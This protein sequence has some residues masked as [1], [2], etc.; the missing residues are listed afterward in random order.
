[1]GPFSVITVK[2]SEKASESCFKCRRKVLKEH[3]KFTGTCVNLSAAGNVSRWHA[4]MFTSWKKRCT[5]LWKAVK[6]SFSVVSRGA[7]ALRA[8]RCLLWTASLS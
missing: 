8:L 5:H 3:V 1:M 6:S 7:A 4:E 2:F